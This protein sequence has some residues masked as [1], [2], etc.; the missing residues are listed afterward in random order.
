METHVECKWQK[1][2]GGS[3]RYIRGHI[4]KANEI[5]V[6]Y[7]HEIPLA[8]RKN[9]TKL[10]TLSKTEDVE[11]SSSEADKENTITK[12]ISHFEIRPVG[13]GWFDIVNSASGKI[14]N[15]Q[16]LRKAAAE[17]VIQELI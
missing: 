16:K 10:E 8:F 11:D 4:I 14:I 17:K 3:L 9:V 13:G 5:F 2:G 6:A 12:S 1:I 7:E 15:E